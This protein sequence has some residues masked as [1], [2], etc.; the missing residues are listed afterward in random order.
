MQGKKKRKEEGV[1]QVWVTTEEKVKIGSRNRKRVGS[2]KATYSQ[3]RRTSPLASGISEAKPRVGCCEQVYATDEIQAIKN[4][5]LPL[6]EK[7]S[8]R[9]NGTTR[10]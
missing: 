9:G 4:T 10:L 5:R 8:R 6:I 1:G 3:V 7:M 2:V